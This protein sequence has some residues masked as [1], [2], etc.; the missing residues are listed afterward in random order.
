MNPK[1]K[2]CPVHPN[3]YETKNNHCPICY[4]FKDIWGEAE[5]RF[6]GLVLKRKEG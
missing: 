1:K 3:V 5:I 4:M 6:D 2:Q